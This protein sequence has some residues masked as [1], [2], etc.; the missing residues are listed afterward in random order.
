MSAY[1]PSATGL[2]VTARPR[3]LRLEGA[4]HH[5]VVRHPEGLPLF[6][7]AADRDALDAQVPGLLGR[8]LARVH[9]YCWMT[10]HVHLA[11]EIEPARAARFQADLADLLG[12]SDTQRPPLLVDAHVYLLRLV[13]YIHL[14][15]QEAQ[16][17][18]DAAEYPWSGH[19]AY[20]GLPGVTWLSMDHALRLLGGDLLW[21]IAAYR[22]LV[23]Q[24]DPYFTLR[25]SA[26]TP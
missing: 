7:T 23:A 19:R 24:P 17:V 13:R 5:V 1:P 14:N 15:P 21:A 12:V 26:G 22:A 6:V 2:A 10:N 25:G 20:L 4:I 18:G 9:A 16:L 11:I 3:L 8:H